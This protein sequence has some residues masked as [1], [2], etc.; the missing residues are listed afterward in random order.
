MK[1]IRPRP[2]QR[3]SAGIAL[4]AITTGMAVVKAG[5]GYCKPAT[6]DEAYPILGFAEKSAEIG[7]VCTVLVSGYCLAI[8]RAGT[9]TKGDIVSVSGSSSAGSGIIA[10]T[11]AAKA[12]GY[13]TED[14]TT[15]IFSIEIP[16]V[17]QTPLPT[18]AI[19]AIAVSIFVVITAF[20]IAAAIVSSRRS[21]PQV[22]DFEDKSKVAGLLESVLALKKILILH[23]E[24]SLPVFEMDIGEKS[25]VEST[26]VSGFL[27]ALTQMGKTISGTEAGEIRKL[28]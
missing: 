7:E 16:T 3:R 19:V 22:M 20:A 23:T 12:V 21:P 25:S 14:S 4:E 15:V 5:E 17:G 13:V 11:T 10:N 28:Q 18:Y 6:E 24:T 8:D 26:L 1:V 2:K 27:A 9:L